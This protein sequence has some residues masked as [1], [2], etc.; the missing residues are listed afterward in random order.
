MSRRLPGEI[1]EALRAS[2]PHQ[3]RGRLS[4][5]FCLIRHPRS[6]TEAKRIEVRFWG[7]GFSEWRARRR[8][9]R[10]WALVVKD[11]LRSCPIWYQNVQ[12]YLMPY[13]GAQSLVC[14]FDL[15]GGLDFPTA[16][17]D[18]QS[19][20]PV[21]LDTTVYEQAYEFSSNDVWKFQSV[22]RAPE[23]P[24]KPGSAI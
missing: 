21:D 14:S 19:E 22:T 24:T 6:E 13:Y 18:Q 9:R 15:M 1:V 5:R 2:V 17:F 4:I 3:F 7:I 10:R 23:I 11:Q 20:T 16:L 8:V 12:I